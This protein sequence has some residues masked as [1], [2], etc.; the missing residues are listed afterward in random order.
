[1][2][3][4]CRYIYIYIYRFLQQLKY[5]KAN[6][7]LDKAAPPHA[8][9][10][11]PAWRSPPHTPPPPAAYGMRCFHFAAVSVYICCSHDRA[12]AGE[13]TPTV[14]KVVCVSKQHL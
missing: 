6:C 9:A 12:Q 10:V 5:A 8:E 1:M 14:A 11:G 3:V 2:Y 7:N 4:M 13:T